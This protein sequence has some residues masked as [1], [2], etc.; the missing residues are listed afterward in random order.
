MT[1]RRRPFVQLL[2]TA[3]LTTAALP[4][5]WAQGR[6]KDMA[7]LGMILEPPGLDPTIAAAAAIGEVVHYNIFESPLPARWP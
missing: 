4:S 5:G 1:I 7:V 6:R 3:G 2:A